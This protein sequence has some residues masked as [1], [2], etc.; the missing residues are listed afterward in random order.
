MSSHHVSRVESTEN[1]VHAPWNGLHR[2]NFA[3]WAICYDV[4]NLYHLRGWCFFLAILGHPFKTY[5]SA[6][7]LKSPSVHNRSL[8]CF[9]KCKR[10][11]HTSPCMFNSDA[12]AGAHC[13]HMLVADELLLAT[14][15]KAHA[16]DTYRRPPVTCIMSMDPSFASDFGFWNSFDITV[17]IL[18]C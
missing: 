4:R 17:K 18:I 1:V 6:Y 2:G 10:M 12:V 9:P 16:N 13:H 5:S 8:V 3:L 14:R 11:Y 7:A 15:R